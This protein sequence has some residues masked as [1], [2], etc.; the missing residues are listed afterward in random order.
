MHG[1]LQ[2]GAVAVVFDGA[3]LQARTV[4]VQQKHTVVKADLGSGL[5]KKQFQDKNEGLSMY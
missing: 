1:G 3:A 2:G 4:V 5:V